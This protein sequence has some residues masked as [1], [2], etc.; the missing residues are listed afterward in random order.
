MGSIA[1]KRGEY[2]WVIFLLA[3]MA[4]GI[5][6]LLFLWIGNKVVNSIKKEKYKVEKELKDEKKKE[7]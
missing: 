5:I 3:A 2:M 4:F 7:N 1:R 6:A